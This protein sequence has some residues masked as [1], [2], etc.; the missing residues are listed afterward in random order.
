MDQNA[1]HWVFGISAMFMAL[2][3]LLAFFTERKPQAGPA[4]SNDKSDAFLSPIG[5]G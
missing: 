4:R 5:G 3:V 2:T 1:P